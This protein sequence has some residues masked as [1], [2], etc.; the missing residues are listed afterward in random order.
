T[1][2]SLSHRHRYYFP[3]R[4]SSDLLTEESTFLSWKTYS[5]SL[6]ICNISD[7]SISPSGLGGPHSRIGPLLTNLTLSNGPILEWGPPSPERSEEHTS[8]L[9][10]RFALVCRLL[11]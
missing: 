11:L 7:H 8:E 3:T 2:A 5:S 4:R 10:S 6:P 1:H 9:Q